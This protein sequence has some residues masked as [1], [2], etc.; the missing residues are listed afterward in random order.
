MLMKIIVLIPYPDFP[1]FCKL[2]NLGSLLY[3][4][5]PVTSVLESH[6]RQ[7]FSR[8]GLKLVYHPLSYD[9]KSKQF[10]PGARSDTK[11]TVHFLGEKIFEMH[12]IL[13]CP[14]SGLLLF[15]SNKGYNV[16]EF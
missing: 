11:L 4:D 1:D 16:G 8:Q 6:R 3:G 2:A 13:D 10:S 9:I 14:D 15:R 5:V 12:S 7:V